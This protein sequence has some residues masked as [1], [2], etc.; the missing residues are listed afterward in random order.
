MISHGFIKRQNLAK[1]K[2]E[3]NYCHK[4]KGIR[5]MD[6]AVRSKFRNFKP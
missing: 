4:L 3:H 1:I 6:K 2:K 5:N